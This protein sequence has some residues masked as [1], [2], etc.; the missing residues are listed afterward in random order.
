MNITRLLVVN[1]SQHIQILDHYVVLIIQLKLIY[2]YM[3]V[4][5]NKTRREMV[6]LIDCSFLP[7]PLLL[8]LPFWMLSFVILFL[9]F[10]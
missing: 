7:V 8:E 2:C 6:V 5:S 3:T 4:I 1:I 9:L 10:M